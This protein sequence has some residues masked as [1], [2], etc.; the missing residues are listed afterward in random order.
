MTATPITPSSS[1]ASAL[2][3]PAEHQRLVNVEGAW[4][5]LAA[6]ATVPPRAGVGEVRCPACGHGFAV[7]DGRRGGHGA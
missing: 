6:L 3:T 5:V 4:A 2:F 1:V 7:G